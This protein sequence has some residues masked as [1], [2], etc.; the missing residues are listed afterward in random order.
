[1]LDPPAALPE[2]AEVIVEVIERTATTETSI[3]PSPLMRYAGQA[4]GLSE[5]ASETIDR[6]LCGRDQA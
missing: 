6:T 4:R 2:G 3:H 1:L 5:D